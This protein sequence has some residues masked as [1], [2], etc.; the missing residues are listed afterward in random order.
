MKKILLVIDLSLIFI[1]LATLGFSQSDAPTTNVNHTDAIGIRL[2]P[3]SPAIQ[4]GITY[5]HFLNESNALEGILSL[6]NGFGICG[7]YEIHKPLPVENVQWLIGGGGYVAFVNSANYFGGAGI[8]G[9][10]Y[11]FPSIPLNLTIDWKPELNLAPRIFFEGSG[12]G[13]SARYTF[14]K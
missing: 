12:V 8:V 6:T 1:S 9:I 2:G 14:G 13:F 7:L 3:T 4:N 5:K 10:D 11:T